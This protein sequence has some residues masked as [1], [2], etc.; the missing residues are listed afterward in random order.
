[1]VNQFN[2]SVTSFT[3]MFIILVLFGIGTDYH[4][5]LFNRFKEELSHGLSINEAILKSYQ[6]AGKS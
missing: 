4:I 6:T 3:Q 5:L 2:F 1:M